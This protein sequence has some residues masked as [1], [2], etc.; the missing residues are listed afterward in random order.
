MAQ[1]RNLLRGVAWTVEG[2]PARVLEG[3][4]RAM[5]GLAVDVFA[6]VFVAQLR[7]PAEDGTRTL[8]WS[9]AGHLPPV[10]VTAE[11]TARLRSSPPDVLLG[12]G[13][14]ARVDHTHAMEPGAAVVV[15]TD[16]L[17]ERRGV[18]LVES[19]GWL[20]DTLDGQPGRT[21]EEL[22]EHVVERLDDVVEDD[23]A[24]LVLRIAERG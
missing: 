5:E 1:V 24:M 3:V 14:P 13:A 17:I 8:R 4:D 6:T 16:G 9:N 22:C 18:S 11:G 7:E 10:L 23:V 2:S 20:V 15:Y 21:A 12:L 19:L